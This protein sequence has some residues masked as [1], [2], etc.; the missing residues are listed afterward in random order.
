M[1]QISGQ[2]ITSRGLSMILH[3]KR[4][5]DVIELIFIFSYAYIGNKE[6]EIRFLMNCMTSRLFRL[7]I[8]HFSFEKNK[9]NI[10]LE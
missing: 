3:V 5:Y 8:S 10:S 1:N 2:L 7:Y 4:G 9:Y 6:N